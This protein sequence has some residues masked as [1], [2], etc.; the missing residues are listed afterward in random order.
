MPLLPAFDAEAM[1]MPIVER[2][3]ELVE[4]CAAAILSADRIGAF[5]LG[6]DALTVAAGVLREPL[7][8]FLA[9]VAIAKTG[10]YAML[11]AATAGL[12]R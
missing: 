1:P 6:G 4:Q 3:G 2:A 8:S 5:P 11:A 7:W 12:M 10:R 9:L